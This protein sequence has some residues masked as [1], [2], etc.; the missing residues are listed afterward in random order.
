MTQIDLT[1]KKPQVFIDVHEVGGESDSS[2]TLFRDY[3]KEQKV[4]YQVKKLEVG[5]L[6]LLGDYAVERKTVSDFCNSLFGSKYGNPRLMEQMKS[7]SE[8]YE[9][10]ILLLE[11]GYTVKKDPN[12]NCIF[13]LKHHKQHKHNEHLYWALERKIGMHPNQFDG[14]L[15]KI[16]E[17]GV[18]VIQTFDK[19]DGVERLKEIF[20]TIQ[21]E[22]EE[23]EK[24]RSPTIRQ[25][26]KLKT[27]LDK[28]I[29]FLSG[30]PQVST[31]RAKKL[32]REFEHPFNV[33]ENINEWDEVKGIGE[34]TVE[35]A[36][37]VLFSKAI[38]EEEE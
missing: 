15:Q 35:K 20:S 26:P 17:M 7:L 19:N 5:D 10:P 38:E 29:F 14:A 1:G 34:K 27:L 9:H 31:V 30:I 25:K 22:G 2:I 21:E 28:Q 33:I 4:F 37:K 24:T 11:G 36:K 32:L 8:T 16:R 6:I 13:Y 3:L 18:E 23:K 12:T